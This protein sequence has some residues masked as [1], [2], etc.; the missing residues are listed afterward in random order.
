M[1]RLNLESIIY[2]VKCYIKLYKKI[3]E[4]IAIMVAKCTNVERGVK[5]DKMLIFSTKQFQRHR[6]FMGVETWPDVLYQ[7]SFCNL[8][9]ESSVFVTSFNYFQFVD[10][11]C[12]TIFFNS[13]LK[14]I[15]IRVSSIMVNYAF[16]KSL[17]SL[18]F[19]YAFFKSLSC[20]TNI[21]L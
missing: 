17:S 11:R 3:L 15:Q 7:Q 8:S 19:N 14:Y 1:F 4:K 10:C 18:I 13:M 12:P 6:F 20:F 16:F 5:S 2:R 9:L 21:I